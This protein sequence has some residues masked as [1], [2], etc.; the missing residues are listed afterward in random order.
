MKM[1][2]LSPKQLSLPHEGSDNCWSEGAWTKPTEPPGLPLLPWGPFRHPCDIERVACPQGSQVK[3]TGPAPASFRLMSTFALGIFRVREE[4]F[5]RLT[6]PSSQRGP[7]LLQTAWLC[8][9]RAG[10]PSQLGRH[11]QCVR[12][13]GLAGELG[14]SVQ[15]G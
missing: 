3:T 14:K 8:P 13:C 4:L 2:D 1:I 15:G 10:R 11:S 12:A 9:L 7:F 6:C 5:P